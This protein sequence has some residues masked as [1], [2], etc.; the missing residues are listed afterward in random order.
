MNS[1]LRYLSLVLALGFSTSNAQEWIPYNPP[2]PQQYIT[3][4]P[5]MNYIYYPQPQPMVYYQPVPYISQQSY[6][7]EKW[8][9]FHRNQ[10]VVSIPEL[11]Y[12]YQPYILYR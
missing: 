6:I 4:Y 3:Q 1:M 8:C 5:L 11:R 2:Q 12:Y 7:V 9:L 10:T